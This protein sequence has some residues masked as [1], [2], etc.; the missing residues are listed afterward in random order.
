MIRPGVV[1]PFDDVRQRV[2]AAKLPEC[3]DSKTAESLKE[4]LALARAASASLLIWADQNYFAQVYDVAIEQPIGKKIE[5]RWNAD[6]THSAFSD[7][8]AAAL[9]ASIIS[10]W[11]DEVFNGGHF[12]VVVSNLSDTFRQPRAL[13]LLVKAES[14]IR[15]INQLSLDGDAK[16]ATFEVRA[17]GTAGELLDTLFDAIDRSEEPSLKSIKLQRQEGNSIFLAAP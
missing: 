12:K 2:R 8:D 3:S 17:S 11:E 1:P 6:Y 14:G 5:S 15:A 7:D 9:A 10:Y 13:R 4:A 16:I